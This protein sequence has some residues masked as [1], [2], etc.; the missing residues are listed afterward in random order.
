MYSPHVIIL[1][2]TEEEGIRREVRYVAAQDPELWGHGV[3]PESRM[4]IPAG[5]FVKTLSMEVTGFMQESVYDK[6]LGAYE[7]NLKHQMT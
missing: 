6:I 3:D 2:K 4:Y 7:R 5:R 1:Y